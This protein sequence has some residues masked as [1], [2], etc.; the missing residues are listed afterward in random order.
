MKVLRYAKLTG[1]YLAAKV[2]DPTKRADKVRE[3]VFTVHA[4]H[5]AKAPLNVEI[6]EKGAEAGM[7]LQLSFIQEIKVMQKIA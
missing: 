2:K 3:L 4:L 1:T 7:P 6:Q 5:L